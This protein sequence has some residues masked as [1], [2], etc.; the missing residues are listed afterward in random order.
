MP[1][2][3]PHTHPSSANQLRLLPE[4]LPYLQQLKLLDCSKNKLRE[5]P[6][7]LAGMPNLVCL[8]CGGCLGGGGPGGG[9]AAR[10]PA[11]VCL[12]CRVHAQCFF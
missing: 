6:E 9:E 8:N 7:A 4:S 3:L 11:L 2:P 10:G 12:N 5:L 1:T